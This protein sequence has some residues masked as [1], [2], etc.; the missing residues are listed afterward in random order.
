MELSVVNYE[1]MLYQQVLDLRQRILRQ[2]LGLNL[3]DEDLSA[4]KDQYIVIAHKEEILQACLMIQIISV[5]TVKFRQMAVDIAYQS[6]GIGSLLMSYAENFCVLNDYV[7]I[8]LH[9]RET[10]IP[11]YEKLK[12]QI[13][14]NEFL[15]V[16]IPHVKMRKSIPLSAAPL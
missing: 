11:F 5:D 10:A 9:A 15:E 2:P 13:E 4:D 1:S 3:Y 6:K 14:G 12:Y 7:H 16:G 8:F